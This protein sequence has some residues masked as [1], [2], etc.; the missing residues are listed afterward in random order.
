MQVQIS[1]SLFVGLTN[2]GAAAEF[3]FDKQG[4]KKVRAD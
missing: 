4:R 2:S 3:E 1:D